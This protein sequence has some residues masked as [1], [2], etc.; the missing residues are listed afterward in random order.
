VSQPILHDCDPGNDDALG[1]LAAAG[2]A[3]LD[4]LAITTQAGHLE[5]D[6]TA[7]NAAIAAAAA[8]LSVPVAAG[9]DRPLVRERLVAGAL[10]REQGLDR[11]RPELTAIA[12]NP[13]H[14]AALIAE[15]ALAHPGVVIACTGPMTNLALALRQAPAIASKLGKIVVLAGAWGLGNKTAAA[16]WNVLSD[17]EAAAIVF[18]AGAPLLMIPIDAAAGVTIDDA[19]LDDIGA[20]PGAACAMAKELLASLRRTHRPGPFGPEDAPLNDPL[21]LLIAADPTLART[22]PARVDVETAGRFT[23]GRTVVDFGG[24]SGLPPNCD[25]VIAID[26]ARAR[27][28]FV[29]A[30]TTLSAR[31]AGPQS[32][33][34]RTEQT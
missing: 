22:L 16:E 10:D 25:V 13:R 23:Y 15:T 5:A 24:K 26:A 3:A 6:R 29:D 17:P 27:A 9:A 11:E 7:R 18:N 28:A 14:G 32:N 31:R 19:L 34:G 20:L 2:L 21:A 8:G 12:L 33:R 4:L 30:L 1:I